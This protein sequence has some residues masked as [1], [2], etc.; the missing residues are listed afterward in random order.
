MTTLQVHVRLQGLPLGYSDSMVLRSHIR[1]KTIFIEDIEVRLRISIMLLFED[2]QR[3]CKL[4]MATGPAHSP[5]ST[6]LYRETAGRI[7]CTNSRH[8]DLQ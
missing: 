1:H 7:Q 8:G 4:A 5:A 6:Q 3:I 2:T